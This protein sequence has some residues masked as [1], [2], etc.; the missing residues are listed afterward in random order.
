[1]S[2][3]FGAEILLNLFGL[4]DQMERVNRCL[5][6]NLTQNGKAT[7]SQNYFFFIYQTYRNFKIKNRK[8]CFRL[9]AL[10]IS[11]AIQMG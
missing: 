1:M 8:V 5:M 9:T 7:L 4:K 10:T 6:S 2:E 11:D 3:V